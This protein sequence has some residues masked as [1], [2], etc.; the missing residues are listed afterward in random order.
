MKPR[1]TH[2]LH[3]GRIEVHAYDHPWRDE[4]YVPHDGSRPVWERIMSA[5]PDDVSTRHAIY[6]SG[7]DSACSCCYLGISHTED[8]HRAC[9][10][11]ASS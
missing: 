11:K 8:K 10:G 4:R 5:G 1:A 2:D 6:P 7:Y 3:Y 9:G